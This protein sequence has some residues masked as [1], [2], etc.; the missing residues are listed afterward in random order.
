MILIAGLP[1]TTT[2]S[3]FDALLKKM[4]SC[5]CVFPY[6]T[7]GSNIVYCTALAFFP[8]KND[9]QK[10]CKSLQGGSLGGY[11]LVVS[12]ATKKEIKAIPK[13]LNPRLSTNLRIKFGDSSADSDS[14]DSSSSSSSSSC[15]DSDTTKRKSKRKDKKTQAKCAK[16][17]EKECESDDDDDNDE[18]AKDSPSLVMEKEDIDV[19]MDSDEETPPKGTKR[20]RAVAGAH[21]T[22]IIRINDEDPDADDAGN[23]EDSFAT[24]SDYTKKVLGRVQNNL[25]I[26][27]KAQDDKINALAKDVNDTT[28]A[29]EGVR[30]QLSTHIKKQPQ[31]TREHEN[32]LMSAFAKLLGKGGNGAPLEIPSLEP[33]DDPLGPTCRLRSGARASPYR[34]RGDDPDTH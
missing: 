23:E 19:V 17:Q 29:V 31:V 2:P 8:S 27:L 34:R 16:R 32:R 7:A 5:R 1:P 4:K 9:R 25:D 13:E 28:K 12:H 11:P 15:T 18:A 14:S 10:Y 21:M 30:H 22:P 33:S 6:I 20:K 3:T 24:V 26:R